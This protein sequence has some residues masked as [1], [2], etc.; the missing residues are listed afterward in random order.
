MLIIGF[1]L[2]ISSIVHSYEPSPETLLYRKKYPQ[3]IKNIETYRVELKKKYNRASS[4][5]RKK[6]LSQAALYLENSLVKEMFPA[7]Y[8]TPWDFNG[9]SVTPGEG[10]IACGYFVS[11]PL[12]HAGVKF[13]RIKMSQQASSNIILSFIAKEDLIKS[14]DI[15]IYE[16]LDKVERKSDGLYVVGLDTH[17]GYLHVRNGEYNFIHSSYYPMNRHVIS[18]P[19]VGYNPL[20][21]SKWRY[22]GKLFSLSMMAKW[23]NGQTFPVYKK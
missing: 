9:T 1:T 14:Y 7:W 16:F 2:L 23:M 6:L 22:A 5:E 17:T 13:N 12:I 11:A 20:S 3:T 21:H 18:Q 19:A 15:T 4:S 10:Q 8:G